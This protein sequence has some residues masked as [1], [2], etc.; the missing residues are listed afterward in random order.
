MLSE[1]LV[2]KQLSGLESDRRCW[3]Q[4]GPVLAEKRVGDVLPILTTNRDRVR[5]NHVCPSSMPSVLVPQLSSL[6]FPL[7]FP[8]PTH[9]HDRV[10]FLL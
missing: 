5:R 8:L 10:A 1:R 9:L 3:Q 7:L 2:L 4:I 6:T